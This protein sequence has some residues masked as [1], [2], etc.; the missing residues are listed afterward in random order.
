MTSASDSKH[1]YN[2]SEGKSQ[3]NK[4][5]IHILYSSITPALK[6][7]HS[8]L[9]YSHLLWAHLPYA[10]RRISNFSQT[11]HAP[12]WLP[13]RLTP[14]VTAKRL[15]SH[16]DRQSARALWQPENCQTPVVSEAVN[17]LRR[18]WTFPQIWTF[19][20]GLCLSTGPNPSQKTLF[21]SSFVLR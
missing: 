2:L 16:M 21:F 17:P 6:C 10:I 18:A 14:S 12:W 8:L 3:P 13:K 20:Q 19:P 11:A 7:A 5:K 15:A 4:G 9:T 1:R